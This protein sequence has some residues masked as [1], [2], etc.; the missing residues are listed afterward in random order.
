MA[1]RLRKSDEMGAEYMAQKKEKKNMGSV[2]LPPV[3]LTALIHQWQQ[4][5]KCQQ[6]FRVL[7]PKV[8]TGAKNKPN[9]IANAFV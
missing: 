2:R 8:N 5:R 9:K 6:Q 1:K 7:W 3:W 4:G